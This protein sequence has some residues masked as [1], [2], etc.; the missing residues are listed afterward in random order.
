MS[1]DVER[2]LVKRY[3]EATKKVCIVVSKRF[4]FDVDDFVE[5]KQVSSTKLEVT[6]IVAP[7]EN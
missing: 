2:G 3:G 4:G 5:V 6:K 1:S 7:V